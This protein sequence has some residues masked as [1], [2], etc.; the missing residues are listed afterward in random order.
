MKNYFLPVLLV[1][2][3]FSSSPNV[4]A[5]TSVMSSCESIQ[6]TSYKAYVNSNGNWHTG[7]IWI[8]QTQNGHQLLSY[9]FDSVHSGMG[10]KLAG[11][12]DQRHRL[13]K[14]NPNNELAK[15]NNVTHYVTIQGL[16]AYLILD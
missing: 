9:N 3:F 16:K 13:T 11:D 1:L 14:L 4:N 15:Q 5:K 8:Q 10:H 12:F 2:L 6:T 7:T